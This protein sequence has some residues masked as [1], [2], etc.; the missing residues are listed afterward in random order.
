MR[1]FLATTLLP[2][3]PKLPASIMMMALPVLA[4][5]WFR[6]SWVVADPAV[7]VCK[8]PVPSATL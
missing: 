2:E 1:G 8:P 4:F 5:P 6:S 7:K 3:E